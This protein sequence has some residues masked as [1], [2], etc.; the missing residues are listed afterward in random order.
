MLKCLRVAGR[1]EYDSSLMS[2]ANIDSLILTKKKHYEKFVRDKE[3][4]KT[5]LNKGDLQ[6]S[7]IINTIFKY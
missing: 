3:S 7:N 1:H 4:K 2:L 6:T 5:K